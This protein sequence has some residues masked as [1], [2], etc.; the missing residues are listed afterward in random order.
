MNAKG[1]LPLNGSKE[2]W[3]FYIYL[4][5]IRYTVLPQMGMNILD[6]IKMLDKQIKVSL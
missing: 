5:D 1:V 6:T 3:G 4:R 2:W